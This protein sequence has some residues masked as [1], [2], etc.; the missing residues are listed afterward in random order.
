MVNRFAVSGPNFDQWRKHFGE[1][2][3]FR[4]DKPAGAGTS[5]KLTR[6]MSKRNVRS[7]HGG[8]A[9]SEQD[10]FIALAQDFDVV[11]FQG[12]VTADMTGIYR[13]AHAVLDVDDLHSEKYKLEAFV[14]RGM[15]PKARLWWLY[16]LWRLWEQ[17]ISKRF[18]AITVCSQD[19]RNRFEGRNNAFV[20][21]NGFQP[22]QDTKRQPSAGDLRLGFIGALY[23]HPNL[24]GVVWFVNEVLPIVLQRF[25][26]LRARIVGKPPAEGTSCVHPNVDWLGFVDDVG[27][28]M[29]TWT[30][31]IVPLR[32]GGG[33]R[34][35][36]LEAL[37]RRCP[38]VSTT[39]GAYGLMLEHGRHLLIADTA[40][41]FAECCIR[42]LQ[43]RALSGELAEAGWQRFIK[44]YT[45]DAVQPA[46]ESVVKEVANKD[47][48]EGTD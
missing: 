36:I 19:D 20:I 34:I 33:T 18:G 1:T 26:G 27:S 22:S 21:P 11:W 40:E 44:R 17:D 46:V 28:E 14:T 47:G 2:E 42:L 24:D 31:S 7:R 3:L 10:R 8:F 32:I 43:D 30:A 37:S 45:W 39:V 12:L 13:M 25:P 6:L 9:D 38:V 23:Y 29:S 48:G 15:I 5:A 41:D 4:A 35:K 16:T